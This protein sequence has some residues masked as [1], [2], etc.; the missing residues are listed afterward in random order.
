MEKKL[1]SCPGN[2]D[3]IKKRMKFVKPIVQLVFFEVKSLQFFDKRDRMGN[4]NQQ[5]IH[6]TNFK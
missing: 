5:T 2:K 6:S 3:N 4:S 1:K